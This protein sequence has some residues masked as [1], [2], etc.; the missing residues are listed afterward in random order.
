VIVYE[1]REG[2]DRHTVG[3]PV[4]VHR[5]EGEMGPVPLRYR[6]TEVDRQTRIKMGCWHR[7][8]DGSEVERSHIKR[9]DIAKVPQ[10]LTACSLCFTGRYDELL[11]LYRK[12]PLQVPEDQ[13]P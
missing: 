5:A 11:P 6:G 13:A 4:L 9:A 12:I 1:Y 8:C 3:Q 7:T 2:N 10:W